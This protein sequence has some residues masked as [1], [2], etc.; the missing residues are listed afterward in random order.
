MLKHFYFPT[1]ILDDAV[2]TLLQSANPQVHTAATLLYTPQPVPTSGTPPA[3]A[4]H[5]DF[6]SP[7]P[8]AFG[9]ID[10]RISSQRPELRTSKGNVR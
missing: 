6:K 10:S 4:Q 3:P 5:R 9:G 2:L 8:H 7:Y 1:L